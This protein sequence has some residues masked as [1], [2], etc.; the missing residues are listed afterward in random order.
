ME[1][2][3]ETPLLDT[4]TASM[5]QVI[6]SRTVLELPLKDGMVLVMATFSPGVIF[7]PE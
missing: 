2:S 1:V 6:D 5:G 4:S 7:L 3:A